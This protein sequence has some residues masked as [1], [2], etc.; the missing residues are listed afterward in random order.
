M[1]KK[2]GQVTFK[3]KKVYEE[4]SFVYPK[5]HYAELKSSS[6]EYEVEVV[7]YYMISLVKL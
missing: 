6:I 3:N 7:I 2:R 5:C 4:S 1:Q